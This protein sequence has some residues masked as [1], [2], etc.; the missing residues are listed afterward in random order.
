MPDKPTYQDL[1]QR[2]RELEA[3][4]SGRKRAEDAL[5]KHQ[6]MFNRVLDSVP[7]SI[8][9]KDHAG[10]YLGC[11]RVFAR[12]VGLDE[13]GQIIGKT[14]YDLPWP[15]EDADAYR[16]DD[17]EVMQNNQPKRHIVE[18]LQQYD[19]VRLWIDTSKAP[20]L[21][22][23]GRPYGVLGIY[24]D[25]TER[26]LMEDALEK[27]MLALTK[28]L[29][30]PEGIAFV[31][32]FNVKDL[33]R[34]QDEF[35]Q[36]TG[37]ASIITHPDGTPITA[38]SNFCR[39]CSE[40]IRQTEAGRI[41]CFHSD[42]VIGRTCAN[43]PTIQTCLSGG[44]WDA[45]AGISVGGRH[46]ANWLIGQVR[47]ETQTEE[48]MR[49]YARA[50]GADEDQVVEAFRIVPAMSREQFGNVSQVLFTLA[51]QLSTLAYQNVQ[52]ARLISDLKKAE[53]E[54]K[55]LQLQLIQAQ[56]M[57]SVGRLAGGV[58]HDFNNML[59]I[60]SG[61][62]ELILQDTDR[63]FPFF[64]NLQEISKAAERSTNLTRQLLAFARK[65]TIAPKVLDLNE[66]L[67]GMLKML[68]RLIG[69]DIDLLWLPKQ[70]LWPVKV[71][72][73]Q[74]DQMLT[75]LC[76]NARDSIEGVGKVTIETGNDR[77]DEAY[78]R[79]HEEFIPGDFVR[80]AVSDNGCGMDKQTLGNLF[81]PFFTTKEVGKGTGLG[82][83]TVYGI[84]KQNHG[85]INVYSEPSCGT[86]FK[87]YLP[88]YAQATEKAPQK[89]S[90][91][92]DV[93]GNETILVVEDEKGILKMTTLVLERLGYTVLA[94]SSPVE[95]IRTVE[96]HAGKID[97]LISDVVM[98]EM[99]GRDMA[100]K[101]LQAYPGLRCL[102]MS[103]YTAEVIAHHGI[104]DEGIH[105]INKPF[106]IK[107]LALKVREIL[108][109]SSRRAHPE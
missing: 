75:N 106:R 4:E 62:A 16:A 32:L 76:I 38:P 90:E 30:D 93:T 47:D 102:F 27:R 19:G 80:I 39:L 3:A 45:G 98:P 108:S 69:E 1:E 66:T 104:L 40:I 99:S 51:N 26:K 33:Q 100:A 55:Y 107:D 10:R 56:K 74:I 97:M 96:A 22:E 81:E 7:Q 68:R 12:A 20:L 41:N 63:D 36:A 91:S 23:N 37:V 24:E 57:E 78:C 89:G 48:K 54:Q 44:L 29:D 84:V 65:Q 18:P 92:A 9:W 83:A 50:I 79:E 21:D 35:A 5:R 109:K 94:A 13:P 34:L 6:A 49:E 53:K 105:F 73:S 82:L 64:E 52:Q 95:A 15:R 8:F 59:S 87:I 88:R 2:V 103:G 72:P 101:L 77:F 60:I 25:I 31:D 14:D 28:P 17:R 58:A 71:D 42:A 67:E 46:L 86:T 70:E 11:N 85:F 61:N 43:G